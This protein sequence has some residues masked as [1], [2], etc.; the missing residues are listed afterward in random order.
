MKKRD[1]L[2]SATGVALSYPMAWAQNYPDKAIRVI[3][4]AQP[5][6]SGDTMTRIITERLASVLGQPMVVEGRPGAGG[7]LAVRA[8]VGSKTDGYTLLSLFSDNVDV[9]PFLSK[10]LPY[11]PMKDLVYI[12]GFG[13]SNP[14]TIAVHPSVKATTFAELLK[15]AKSSPQPLKYGTYGI[16]SVPQ[17]SFETL[18]AKAGIQLL[19]VPY[20][21]G[22]QSYQAAVAGEVDLVAGTSFVELVKAGRL[23][24]L[25]VGGKQRSANFPEVPTLDELGYGDQI[26]TGVLFGFAAPAGTPKEVVDRLSNELRKIMQQG[27]DLAQRMAPV[28]SEPFFVPP[29]QFQEMIRKRIELHEP[30][31][32]RLGLNTQ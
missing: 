25:A 20:K 9:V 10:S 4:G 32:K 24:P 27:G 15:L 14:F 23:R 22:A 13:R 31:I 26:F 29:D 18:A 6:A 11:D 30:V 5:G 16:G 17:L 2:I 3:V 8:V 19:H 1:F 21:G 7:S 28:A 12:G